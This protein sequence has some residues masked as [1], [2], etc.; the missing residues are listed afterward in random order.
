MN[1]QT[2]LFEDSIV[3]SQIDQLYG[4]MVR[5]KKI[6]ILQADKERSQDWETVDLNSLKNKDVREIGAEWLTCQAIKEL[7]IES[8]LSPRGWSSCNIQLA[9]SHLI[10]R[11]VYPASELKTVRF[12]QDNSAVCELTGYPV[13]DINQT[14]F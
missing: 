3:Q 4:Q 1:G 9:I 14:M 12:M 8:Y 7:D 10:S 5:E 6:D 2:T 13:N 11:A